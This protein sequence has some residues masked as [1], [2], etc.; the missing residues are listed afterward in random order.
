[1]T[2]I[3]GRLLARTL[4]TA[5]VEDLDNGEAYQFQL[6][7]KNGVTKD[8]DDGGPAVTGT[9]TPWPVVM[10]VLTPETVTEKGAATNSSVVTATVAA[11]N[12]A[13]KPFTVT[14][15]AEAVSPAVAGDFTLAGRTLSFAANATA[16]TGDV[17]ITAVDNPV[18]AAANAIVTVSGTMSTGSDAP[19]SVALTITDEDAVPAAPG[20]FAAAAGDA[21]VTLTWT[22]PDPEGTSDVTGFEYRYK[23][24]G[25]LTA[26]DTWLVVGGGANVARLVV[27]GL[28]SGEVHNFQL[29]AV[30]A[31][32]NSPAATRQCNANR[33]LERRNSAAQRHVV[34]RCKS[35]ITRPRPVRRAGATPFKKGVVAT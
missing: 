4:R 34:S 17:K 32:G 28:T 3:R 11:D 6:R 33:R 35:R 18:D 29:R 15:S 2:L 26:A 19:A 12:A 13:S 16:A 7:A 10:L 14:V 31:A 25:A 9:G 21:Q 27:T 8:G 20:G 22:F 30:S 23:E 5:T 24:D 1:M